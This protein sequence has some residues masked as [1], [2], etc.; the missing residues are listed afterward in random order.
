MN[1][2]PTFG[3]LFEGLVERDLSVYAFANGWKLYHYQNYKNEEIDAVVELNDGNWCAF[4]IKLGASK[5]EEGAQNLNKVCNSIKE[6]GRT[7]PI[8]KAVICGLSNAF[9]QRT[10]G[11]YVIPITSLKN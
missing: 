2:L 11:V 1:D 3:F 9:Y 4:E 10:D 7:P 8:I 6:S 5:I